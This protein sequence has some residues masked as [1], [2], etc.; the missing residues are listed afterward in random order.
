MLYYTALVIASGLV[1]ERTY[2]RQL[3]TGTVRMI[4]APKASPPINV[5]VPRPLEGIL[6]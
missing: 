4:R 3:A 6:G 5:R 1:F 2:H